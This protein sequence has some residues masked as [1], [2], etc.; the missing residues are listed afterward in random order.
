[1]NVAGKWRV[2]SVEGYNDDYEK[3]WID[4]DEILR[5]KDINDSYKLMLESV[6]VFSDDGYIKRLIPVPEEFDK[7]VID[8]AVEDGEIEAFQVGA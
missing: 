2:C 4:A 6:F 8:K 5:D 1:M 7:E 3:L